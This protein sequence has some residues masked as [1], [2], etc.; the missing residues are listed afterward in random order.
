MKS[1]VKKLLKSRITRWGFPAV[2]LIAVG[3]TVG[4]MNQR[5]YRLGGGFIGTSPGLVWWA[6]QTPLDPDGRTAALLVKTVDDD[7]SLAGLITAFGGD[8]S[9]EGVGE[10]QMISRDTAE[11]NMVAYVQLAGVTPKITAIVVYTGTVQFTGPDNILLNYTL[12]I[13]PATADVNPHDGFPD[14]GAAPALILPGVPA[15][16]KRVPIPWQ[17]IGDL[18]NKSLA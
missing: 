2:L 13:Y 5:H 15:A 12:S 17:I 16:G 8:T 9:T 1:I 6:V 3:V 11:L 18:T 10:V 14:E 7:G 4:W